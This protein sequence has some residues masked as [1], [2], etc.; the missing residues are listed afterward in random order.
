MHA[1]R[2]RAAL[3]G[4][5]AAVI[6][7]AL[8]LPTT[9]SAKPQGHRLALAPVEASSTLW[10]GWSD[11]KNDH[12]PLFA[13]DASAKTAWVEGAEGD[14]AGEWIRFHVTPV[15][16]VDEVTL[17]LRN[18][19]QQDRKAFKR[20]ARLARARVVMQPGGA[21]AEV[22]LADKNG[23]QT[24]TVPQPAGRLESVELRIEAVHRGGGGEHACLSEVEVYVPKAADVDPKVQKRRAREI[25]AWKKARRKTA[26][27]LRTREGRQKIPFAPAMWP[28]RTVRTPRSTAGRTISA[29]WKRGCGRCKRR[30]ATRRRPR[31]PGAWASCATTGGPR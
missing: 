17:R 25:K 30:S 12:H 24:H 14:G 8:I 21:E 27:R 1:V 26:R 9:A 3:T 29:S 22:E 7:A 4:C 23:W 13:A 28:A 20:F 5:A 18:G 11:P 2:D 31:W 16:G 19:C 10:R 15:D 6:A